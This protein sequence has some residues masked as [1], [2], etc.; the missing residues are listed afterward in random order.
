VRQVK[1]ILYYVFYINFILIIIEN[2]CHTCHACHLIL[3]QEVIWW[4]VKNKPVTTRH[5]PTTNSH[6]VEFFK[7][8]KPN[9][10]VSALLDAIKQYAKLRMANAK[11]DEDDGLAELIAG[12]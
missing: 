2:T 11:E 7:Q 12:L 8:L 6:M 5:T 4:Q 3:F 10:Q 9:H 1:Y